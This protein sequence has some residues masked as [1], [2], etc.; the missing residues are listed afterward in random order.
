MGDEALRYFKLMVDD[1][2]EPNHYTCVSSIAAC[3]SI[4]DV[5]AGKE[6]HAK[7][8]RI[9]QELN[10]HV[11]N[12]LINMYGKCGLL[13]WA[14]RVFNATLEPN[15][16]SWSSLLSSYCQSGNYVGGLEVFLESHKAG[17]QVNEFTCSSALGASAAL[18]DLKAGMQVHSLILKIGVEYDKFIVTGLINFYAK[19]GELDL[20]FQAFTEVEHPQPSAWTALIGGYVQQ[21]RGGK[22]IDIFQMLLSSGLKPNERTLA[23]V[24][25]AFS[26]KLDIEAGKQLHSLITKLGFISFIFVN[27]AILDFYSKCGL[28][29]ECVKIFEEM[30]VHDVVSWNALISG[31]VRAGSYEDAVKL[32]KD[33]LSEGFKPSIFTYSSILSICGDIPAIEWGKQTH[34]CVLKPGF[35]CNVVVGSTLIDMYAKCGRLNDARKVF[36]S[37]SSKNLV[38]WNSML[39]GYAQHGCG[40]EALEIYDMMQKNGIVPSDVTFIGIL[41]ACGHVGFV[42]EGWHFFNSMIKDYGISP[43]MDHIAS[44]VDL[45]SRRGQTQRAYEFIKS[46]PVEPDK[47]V[48]RCLLS[49]CKTSKDWALGRYAAEQILRIDPEDTSAHIMLSNIYAEAKMWDETAQV[50]RIMKEKALKKDTGYSWI[51]LKNKI[52]SFPAGHHTYFK[53]TELQELLYGL[54]AH[55]LDAGYKSE[56]IS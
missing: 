9:E 14:R 42:E 3:A 33:M 28:L 55:L 26:D 37:L 5:R 29:E 48:W 10:S 38:S 15:L 49:G 56:A 23:S 43:K 12:S 21:G 46:F 54:T 1:G 34:C 51:E 6:I 22:A 45:F 20:A 11:S 8:Y 50:R 13:N 19:C 2:Y 35:E 44:L 18:E 39:V 27:N 31:H 24:L 17:V 30:G 40:K 32:L 7:I 4:G 41:S 16:V 52:Y 47:V 36:D 53:E 25:G